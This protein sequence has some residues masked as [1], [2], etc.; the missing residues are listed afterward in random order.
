MI[1][2][3]ILH[4]LVCI[5]IMGGARARGAPGNTT[6]AQMEVGPALPPSSAT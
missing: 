6:I 5:T 1:M 3:Y 4:T 2:L